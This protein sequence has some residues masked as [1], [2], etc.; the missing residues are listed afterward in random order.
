MKLFLA[1]VQVKNSDIGKRIAVFYVVMAG[2]AEG[3]DHVTY[4]CSKGG[5]FETTFRPVAESLK[6]EYVISL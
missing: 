2:I 1:A 5:G 4:S 3:L 6:R